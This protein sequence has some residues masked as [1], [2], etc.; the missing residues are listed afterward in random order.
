LCYK[1]ASIKTKTDILIPIQVS[2]IRLVT[3]VR[4]SETESLHWNTDLEI[5]KQHETD[6]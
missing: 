1:V 6:P 3:L 4:K 2:D 5:A